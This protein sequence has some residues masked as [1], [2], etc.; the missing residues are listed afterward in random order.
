MKKHG[1]FIT[2]TD[3]GV[4]KTLVAGAIAR[5]LA[6]RGVRCGVMKP[7]ESGCMPGKTGLI[8]QDG[9]YL[10]QAARSK[11]PLDQIT[12]YR[13]QHPLAPYAAMLEGETRTISAAHLQKVFGLLH[14][15]HDFLIVEGAGGLL[16]P[17]GRHF[18]VAD[19]IKLL[20]L[21]VL[22]VARSGL[23]T[24]NHTLLSLHHGKTLGL[25]FLGVMLNRSTG[26]SAPSEKT[27]LKILDEQAGHPIW[28]PFPH[29]KAKGTSTHCIETAALLLE[30]ETGLTDRIQKL[31]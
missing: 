5:W 15:R 28:G 9:R 8:P 24:L 31:L 4:G 10:K 23:G 29:I 13:F 30:E 6:N 25:S 22:L 21:P 12:P 27:N 14:D 3:T 2:G 17:L 26:E 11:A 16:A 1:L 18:N 7:V 20:D 19:L